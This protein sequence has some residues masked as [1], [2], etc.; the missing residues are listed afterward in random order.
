MSEMLNFDYTLKDIQN[1]GEII[2]R[3]SKELNM[4]CQE[5]LRYIL[6]NEDDRMIDTASD[7]IL[8]SKINEESNY[9]PNITDIGENDKVPEYME[10]IF[11]II[12][13]ILYSSNKEL[14]Y[15]IPKETTYLRYRLEDNIRL[16]AFVTAVNLLF[17]MVVIDEKDLDKC[18]KPLLCVNDEIKIVSKDPS[19]LLKLKKFIFGDKAEARIKFDIKHDSDLFRTFIY[20]VFDKD[21]RSIIEN[22]LIHDKSKVIWIK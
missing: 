22:S 16:T 21:L 7:M 18:M 5:Y 15:I 4:T 10:D 17:K 13:D 1:I 6:D 3:Q 14:D 19:W 12:Y 20:F 9:K 11:D 2:N 8:R